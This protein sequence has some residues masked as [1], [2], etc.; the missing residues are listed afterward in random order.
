[1]DEAEPL[2]FSRYLLIVGFKAYLLGFAFEQLR[3][4]HPVQPALFSVG[5]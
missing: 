5:G 3:V 4:W 2:R 1:M